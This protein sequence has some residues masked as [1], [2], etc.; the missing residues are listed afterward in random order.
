[1]ILQALRQILRTR[2][3]AGQSSL[4]TPE[5]LANPYPIYEYLRTTDPV[6]RDEADGRW[7]ITRY[8][9]VVSVLRNPTASSARG[10]ALKVWLP[11]QFRQL[12]AMRDKSMINSDAPAHKR[13]RL[14]VSKAFTARAIE[15]MTGKIQNLVDGFLDEVQ[16][17]G[18][19]DVIADLAY[20]LPVTV[21]AEM[22]GVPV[23]DRDRFKHWSDEL[24]FI[25]G[26][27][28]SPAALR[29]AD[30]R[31][32]ARSMT[33]LTAYLDRIVAE[34]RVHPRNDLLS[35]LAQAEEAGDRLSTDEL[36]ANAVLLLV[37]GNETTTNLIGNGTLA[38][39]RHPD[40]LARLKADPSLL[41]T[42]IEELLR[43]DSPVQF[44]TRVLT[45]DETIGGKELKRGEMVLLGL[46]AANRDPEQFPEPDR[47]DIGRPDNKHLSFGLGTHFCLGA[48]LAR[49]EVR[50]ALETLLRRMPG[51]RLEGA[52]P[53]YRAHFNLRGLKALPVTF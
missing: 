2:K 28:G 9:D 52:E 5:T 11:P 43:Y 49:L 4:F 26:G 42:A 38:L 22:L 37:A 13:L 17:H 36:Y 32:V 19:M 8:A 50:I 31:R 39:L 23:E 1:M 33:E 29:V 51:L 21:I 16:G 14:L 25:A 3:P 48:Q 45:E 44:T 47:L 34:R 30:Y 18:R 40:Q 15:A 10:Q 7:I 41:P 20:P 12:A 6:H 46:G 35:A 24:S 53:E 27:A